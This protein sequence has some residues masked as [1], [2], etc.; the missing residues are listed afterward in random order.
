MHLESNGKKP[1]SISEATFGARV[2][3]SMLGRVCGF[4]SSTIEICSN[5]CV[6]HGKVTVDPYPM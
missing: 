3:R 2:S 1:V 6:R 5:D 4:G